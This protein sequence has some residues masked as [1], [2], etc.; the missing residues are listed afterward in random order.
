[1]K[2]YLLGEKLGH[3][4]SPELHRFYGDYSYEKKEHAK[5]ELS[6][7]FAKRDFDALNITV[8]Y[9][10]DVIEFC[11]IISTEA[12]ETHSVNTIVNSNGKLYGHNTDVYGFSYLL[13]KNGISVDNK[14]V[15][16]LGS[17]G[18][19]QAVKSVLKNRDCKTV[20]VSRSGEVTYADTEKYRDAEIVINC[21]PVG[22]YP[23][24]NNS[25][26]DV[27][28]FERIEWA[29]DL[30]YNPFRTLFLQSA[31]KQ[32]ANIVN[33]LDMLCAQGYMS[34]KLF[35]DSEID[36]SLIE[37]AR[38]SLESKYTNIAVIGMPGSGKTTLAEKFSDYTGRKLLDT[39][40][41]ITEETERTPEDIIN[42]DGEAA[43]RKIEN[44]ICLK[45][46]LSKESIISC[47]GGIVCT[48]ENITLLRSV[49]VVLYIDCPLSELD[50]VSRPL[51]HNVEALWKK[52][53][54]LYEKCADITVTRDMKV[55]EIL[56]KIT[57]FI[58]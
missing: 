33:G 45:A 49:S 31:A 55:E 9:K 26:C 28:V 11:D 10:R 43:F 32:G 17:G 54:H 36:F 5:S 15:A 3:S 7:F 20:T 12:D 56:Q 38:I 52:R 23:N 48:P 42:R 44:D 30:T 8:P 14:T 53:K 22:M 35:T 58:K 24:I 4:L 57:E 29:I 41:L 37:K 51:S 25:P 6:D 13:D 27:S 40:K 19:A 34:A 50:T 21:T 16:I 39:D 46:C 1:M 2:I 18:A 47:G